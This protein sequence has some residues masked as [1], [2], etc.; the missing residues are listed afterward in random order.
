MVGL[1]RLITSV[2]SQEPLTLEVKLTGVLIFFSLLLWL[3]KVFFSIN[4]PYLPLRP[5]LLDWHHHQPHLHRRQKRFCP[6]KRVQIDYLHLILP[7]MIYFDPLFFSWSLQLQ[8]ILFWSLSS[9]QVF[10]LFLSFYWAPFFS[11]GFSCQYFP[12]QDFQL[13]F[14]T[15]FSWH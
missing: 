3:F 12:F 2:P 9:W 15:Y 6:K 7:R 8:A 13:S 1:L 4:A 5:S 11:H 10:F 14:P